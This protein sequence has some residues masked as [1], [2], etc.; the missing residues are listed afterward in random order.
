MLILRE[1][2]GEEG[3]ICGNVN[4][5]LGSHYIWVTSIKIIDTFILYRMFTRNVQK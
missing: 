1:S 4:G 2:W 5:L 3:V